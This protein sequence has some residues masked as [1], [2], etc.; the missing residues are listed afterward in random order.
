MTAYWE[1]SATFNPSKNT[2]QNQGILR[3]SKTS[4]MGGES[5]EITTGAAKPLPFCWEIPVYQPKLQG[6]FTT[7]LF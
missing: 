1:T 6:V 5:G 2:E 3:L 7:K 4:L